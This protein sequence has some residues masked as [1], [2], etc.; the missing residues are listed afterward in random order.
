MTLFNEFIFIDICRVLVLD[1]MSWVLV[2]TC[3]EGFDVP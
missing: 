3:T 1:S 2:R